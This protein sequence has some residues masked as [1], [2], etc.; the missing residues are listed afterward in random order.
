MD[1]ENAALTSGRQWS[2]LGDLE[3]RK[4][5]SRKRKSLKRTKYM[6]R[7][8]LLTATIERWD[9]G[10]ILHVLT[11]GFTLVPHTNDGQNTQLTLS[12]SQISSLSATELRYLPPQYDAKPPTKAR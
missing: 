6:R 5:V 10:N 7:L 9:D 11:Q 2:E 8:L 12:R 1:L 4:M 3:E